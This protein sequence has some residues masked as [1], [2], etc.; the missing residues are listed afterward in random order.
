MAFPQQ[1]FEPADFTLF[2]DLHQPA[3]A[4]PAAAES[5]PTASKYVDLTTTQEFIGSMAAYP[6]PMCGSTGNFSGECTFTPTAPDHHGIAYYPTPEESLCQSFAPNDS[7]FAPLFSELDGLDFLFEDSVQPLPLAPAQD[8]QIDNS[9][10]HAFFPSME[11]MNSV[12]AALGFMPVEHAP[13]KEEPEVAHADLSPVPFSISDVAGI[14]SNLVQPVPVSE[15]SLEGLSPPRSKMRRKPSKV[16]PCPMEVCNKV[17]TRKFNLQTHLKTHD[18]ARARPYACPQC[19][20]DFM[21]PH[22]LER[23]EAVHAKVKAH[24]CPGIGCTKR[25]TR[26][27]ALRRHMKASNCVDPNG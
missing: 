5:V 20:K 8:L 1:E 7:Q 14:I 18:P 25:F 12:D 19:D 10:L 2:G 27:D 3:P 11:G 9:T 21:R 23:H 6:S 24:A 15:A 16:Y 13:V 4:V 17:F 26:A 22:D